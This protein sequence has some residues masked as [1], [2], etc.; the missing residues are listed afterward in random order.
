MIESGR[1]GQ[2]C[3]GRQRSAKRGAAATDRGVRLGQFLRGDYPR[4]HAY[5]GEVRFAQ[6]VQACTDAYPSDTPSERW[7]SRHLP[8]FLAGCASFRRHPELAEL[9][10]L[11][12]ALAEAFAAPESP[13]I[14][15][16]DVARIPPEQLGRTTF[17]LAP[18]VRRFPVSTNV[19]TIWA[20]LRCEERPPF[21]IDL[22]APLQVMVWRQSLGSRFRI[23]GDEEAAAIDAMAKGSTFAEICGSIARFGGHEDAPARA[24][25][26]L[27]GWVE[28]EIIVGMSGSTL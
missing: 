4:L 22:Q 21:P 1:P 28:A 18:T 17:A 8:G 7:Y 19:T 13:A 27:R 25:S 10:R 20:A 15:M 14:A 6:L 24:A 9:A 3:A 5:L 26:Y 16:Q 2:R 11:E 23:L 12:N